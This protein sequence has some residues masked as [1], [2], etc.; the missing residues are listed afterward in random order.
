MA[1]KIKIAENGANFDMNYILWS[2]NRSARF[3]RSPSAKY[4]EKC[5]ICFH[6]AQCSNAKW[7]AIFTVIEEKINPGS[8]F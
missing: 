7:R 6:C 1:E 8:I 5:K 3:A 2:D 4:S